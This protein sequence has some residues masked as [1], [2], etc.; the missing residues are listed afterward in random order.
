MDYMRDVMLSTI[1][2][3]DQ[4]KTT[5]GG[6]AENAGKEKRERVVGGQA[7]LYK[8]HCIMDPPCRQSCTATSAENRSAAADS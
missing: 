7:W 1:D 4:Q 8:G 2:T 5:R 6:V 3:I